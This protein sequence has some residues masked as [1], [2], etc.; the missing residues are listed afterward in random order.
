M[1][2]V[3]IMSSFLVV[4]WCRICL[5]VQEMG[6]QA[7]GGD[8][9]L[10]KEMATLFGLLAWRIPWTEWPG[11]LQPMRSRRV[12]DDLV[13]NSVIMLLSVVFSWTGPHVVI[14]LFQPLPSFKLSL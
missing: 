12:G 13:I 10:E 2:A 11:G 14:K 8:D 6:F 9:L 3:I 1:L 7:L 5:P 4:Q